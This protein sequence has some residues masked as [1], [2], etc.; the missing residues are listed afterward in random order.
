V[1]VGILTGGGDCPGLNAVIRAVVRKGEQVFGDEVIGFLDAWDGV[2]ER[3]TMT[4]DVASLRG[5]LPK[6]GTLL[7]TRRGSPYD[8]AG[9][10]Q[11]VVDTFRDMGI[12]ALLVIGGNGSLSVANQMF[13]DFGLP[14]I[15][16]PK[17]IDN[18]VVGTDLTFGFTTAVQIAT[19]AIDR[20]HTTAESHDRVMVVEVMGRHTGWI[21]TH[22]GIAG[23]ATV[24]LI[25]EQPFDIDEVCTVLRRR[26]ERG[27][28]ASIVVVAEGAE[29]AAGTLPAGVKVYDQFGHVRLGGIAE[30]IA[31]NIESRTGFEARVV[32]LGHVQRGGTPTAFDRV[33]A[34]RYGV[35]AIDAVHQQAWGQMTALRGNDIVLCP[36][37][38]T[39]GRTRTLD[40]E[41]YRDVASI[42]F[43]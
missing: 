40:L 33:L 28:Y 15:G 13:N 8:H 1:R 10:P 43:G 2:M 6:G 4:L 30:T 24:I 39:G 26:H 5:M 9:G 20:L 38:E 22:A 11:R 12:D 7:G 42:F 18:D 21:A 19:D 36:L 17:T 29:P 37:S 32:L 35:A 41:L 31:H 16:V 27:R 34:T 25:P 3:R 23:G 14:I